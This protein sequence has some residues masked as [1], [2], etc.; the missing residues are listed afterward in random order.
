MAKEVDKSQ[1]QNSHW[2]IGLVTLVRGDLLTPVGRNRTL[3]Y[4]DESFSSDLCS[5]QKSC[6]NAPSKGALPVTSPLVICVTFATFCRLLQ[7]GWK[8]LEVVPLQ[9]CRRKRILQT[10]CYRTEPS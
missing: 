2:A 10:K 5:Y 6:T 8:A 4:I 9:S 7:Q 1:G 3:R